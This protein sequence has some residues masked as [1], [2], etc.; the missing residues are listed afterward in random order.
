MSENELPYTTLLWQPRPSAWTA[1]V[2]CKATFVIEPNEMRLADTHEPVFETDSF[3]DDDANRSL[4]SASDYVPTKAKCDVVLV[5]QAFAP[6]GKPVR[7]LVARLAFESIDKQLEL[8]TDRSIGPDGTIY[9]GARFVRMPIVYERAAGGPGTSNPVGVRPGTRDAYGRVPLPN[10]VPV[11]KGDDASAKIEPIGFGPISPS[12]PARLDRLGYFGSTFSQAKLAS[13]PLPDGFDTN[14]FNCAPPDQQLDA[15]PED[16]AILLE[17][18]HREHARVGAKLPGLRPRVTVERRGGP[19]RPQM[20]ADTLSIDTG[21]GIVTITWRGHVSLEHQKET[22]RVKVEVERM[23]PSW[24]TVEHDVARRGQR[25][26]IVDMSD[27]GPATAVG[28]STL[29]GNRSF[30]RS[31][32]HTTATARGAAAGGDLPFAKSARG[33]TTSNLNPLPF[34]GGPAKPIE[35]APPPA[36]PAS[37]AQPGTM[38]IQ[39]GLPFAKSET[40][41][42]GP[43]P[44]P[45]PP[46]AGAGFWPA[47]GPP[48]QAAAPIAAPTFGA[49]PPVAA[50]MPAPLPAPMPAPAMDP[51]KPG[52][53][54]PA[55]GAPS[56]GAPAGIAPPPPAMAHASAAALAGLVSASNAAADPRATGANA[57]PAPR[58]IEGDVLHL[59]WFNPDV[60]PRVRRKPEWKKL[61]DK[62]EQGPFDPEV[63]QAGDDDADVEDRREVFEV[64]AHGTP[65]GQDAIDRALLEAVRADGRFA[66]QL[67]LLL[68]ELR[69]DFDELE[70]LKATLSAATPFTPNDEEL[71]KSVDAATAFLGT[72]GLVAAPDVATAMTQKIKDAFAVGNRPVAATYLDDQTERALLDRR[73]YQKRSVFGAPHLRGMFF[74]QGSSTG[75][76]TYLP[77]A[78]G[79]KLPLFRRLRVRLL[80]EAQFQADQYESHPAALKSEAI[81]RIVR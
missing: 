66:P 58:W 65:A 22:F 76:P 19:D 44:P 80:A 5:G 46:S 52:A 37:A 1:T 51:V 3:W 57:G 41:P 48:A 32:S 36:P 43:P 62:L 12:W 69:F 28:G 77:E 23:T 10:I 39:S 34:S 45:P 2:I 42:P 38:Q 67:L 49:V 8:V 71:K 59:L 13:E 78:V 64:I 40:S 14:Y 7:S 50:P 60:A 73:A 70:T 61:L 72:P 79:K 31:V 30:G 9:Q 54:P 6:Q 35:P 15:I 81:A 74:F 26:T 63:D 75:I 55:W 33:E 4:S 56:I 20:R 16:G 53:A 24:R 47:G 17:N 25:E 29:V 21:R 27:T 68:G 11:G 18:L